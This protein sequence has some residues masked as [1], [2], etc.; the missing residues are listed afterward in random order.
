MPE[1]VQDAPAEPMERKRWTR[2]I[3]AA[4]FLSACFFW[5]LRF[6]VLFAVAFIPAAALPL[7]RLGYRRGVRAVV[8][9]SAGGA[10]LAGLFSLLLRQS[11]ANSIVES[12]IFLATAGACGFAG[13]VSRTRGASAIFLGLCLYGALG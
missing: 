6:L 4:A 11:L 8:A 1:P 3:L 7:V 13:A 12:G 10:L 5:G 2:E 9:A